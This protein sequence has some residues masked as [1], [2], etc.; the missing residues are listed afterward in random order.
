MW[1][2]FNGGKDFPKVQHFQVNDLVKELTGIDLDEYVYRPL[3]DLAEAMALAEITTDPSDSFEDIFHRIFLE[4]VDPFLEKQGL[5]FL[6]DFPAPLRALARIKTENKSR[7]ARFEFYWGSR[8]LGNAFDET[9]DPA[10]V[11]AVCLRDQA[12]RMELYGDAPPLDQDFLAAHHTLQAPIGGIAMGLDRL[13][14]WVL[15]LPELKDVIAFE[16]QF[17]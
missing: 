8:E 17:H 5:S 6:W 3:D 2:G 7:C 9:T 1:S 10:E 16:A 14:Q 11:E 15:D 12:R 4:K 13:L